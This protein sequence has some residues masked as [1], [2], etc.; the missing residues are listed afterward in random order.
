MKNY[1]QFESDLID[2]IFAAFDDG[3]IGHDHVRILSNVLYDYLALMEK[4]IGPKKRKVHI[5]Q[6][7]LGKISG[8]DLESQ[9]LNDLVRDMEQK[10]TDGVDVNGH[11]SKTIFEAGY[12]DMLLN[13]WKIKHIHLGKTDFDFFDRNRPMSGDL[14]FASVEYDNAYFLDV[15]G[16]G[17][18][19]VFCLFKFLQIMEKNWEKELLTA[20]PEIQS[21]SDVAQS[22]SDI[23]KMRAAHV[24]IFIYKINGKFYC[25]KNSS[26]YSVAGQDIGL[27]FKARDLVKYYQGLDIEYSSLNFLPYCVNDMGCIIDKAG[28]KYPL[29]PNFSF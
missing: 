26:G 9:R 4:F 6:E 29:E 12:N 22:D 21:L 14:L 7:L 13:D 2:D 18:R 25:R 16:H 15:E 8:S 28:N 11:L 23:K 5:S 27:F 19:N 17:V 1:V 20:L 24:N 10:M 3:G